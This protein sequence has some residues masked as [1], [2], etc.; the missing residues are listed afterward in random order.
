MRLEAATDLSVAMA[1]TI[2]RLEGE[3]WLAEGGAEYG[4]VFIRRGIDRRQLTRT[5][6]NPNSTTLQSFSPVSIGLILARL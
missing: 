6:Q 4:F 5:P 2:Q 3:G 1:V